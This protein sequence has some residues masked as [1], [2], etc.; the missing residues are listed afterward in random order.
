MVERGIGNTIRL[1]EKEEKNNTLDEQIIFGA[2]NNTPILAPA[3][4]LLYRS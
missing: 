4:L 3:P 2:L 1:S